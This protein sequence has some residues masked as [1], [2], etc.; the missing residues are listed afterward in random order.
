MSWISR[1]PTSRSPCKPSR[2]SSSPLPKTS[3]GK[4]PIVPI[5]RLV[6]CRRLSRPRRVVRLVF[7]MSRTP[8]Q[9]TPASA[10]RSPSGS[11]SSMYMRAGHSLL[12]APAP[13][14]PLAAP[15]LDATPPLPVPATAPAPAPDAP[16]AP[17]E[18][19]P[20]DTPP[21]MPTLWPP[22]PLTALSDSAPPQ[23]QVSTINMNGIANLCI[24]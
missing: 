24:A 7:V 3:P 16:E 21:V 15:A 19:A 9:V 11:S 6:T 14:P 23:P 10:A 20:P 18:V 4:R 22:A 1:F 8:T 17:P 13:S 2:L 12:P 5:E